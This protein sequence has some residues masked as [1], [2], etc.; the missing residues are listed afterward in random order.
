VVCYARSRSGDLYFRAVIP[1]GRAIELSGAKRNEDGF[2][3][4]TEED[5]KIFLRQIRKDQLTILEDESV[6]SS[7]QWRVGGYASIPS[8]SITPT[9]SESITP[10]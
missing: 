5:G 10:T 6:I 1:K 4:T 2:D 8:E 3:V 7:E 9:P